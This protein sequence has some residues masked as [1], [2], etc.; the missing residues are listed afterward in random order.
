MFDDVVG[1]ERVDQSRK[2][3][4]LRL[5]C[6][7]LHFLTRVISAALF[8]F[9]H[10]HETSSLQIQLLLVIHSCFLLY[11]VLLRPYANKV[12]MLVETLCTSCEVGILLLAMV[13]LE[14]E[15]YT[16][17]ASHSLI[18]LSYLDIGIL[19]SYELFRIGKYVKRALDSSQDTNTNSSDTNVVKHE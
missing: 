7:F 17:A 6:L 16:N 4:T 8:G 14:S 9:F 18:T 11:L 19:M 15:K 5:L 3:S 1:E 10:T 2:V 13:I 12:L